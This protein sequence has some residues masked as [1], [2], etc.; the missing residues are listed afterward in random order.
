MRRK[1][2]GNSLQ[3]F[4]AM[5]LKDLLPYSV[6]TLGNFKE[7]LLFLV[8]IEWSILVNTSFI[9]SIQSLFMHDFTILHALSLLA[10]DID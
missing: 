8:L 9:E 5:N 4:A 6:R 2:N 1:F 3:I 10:P 7:L